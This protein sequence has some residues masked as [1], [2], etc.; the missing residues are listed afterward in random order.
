MSPQ[1]LNPNNP[2]RSDGHEDRLQSQGSSRPKGKALG[3]RLGVAG[4]TLMMIAPP[5]WAI[6]G[7]QPERSQRADRQKQ[8]QVR[9]HSSQPGRESRS[10]RRRESRRDRS[11]RRGSASQRNH[12]ESRRQGQVQ[13]RQERRQETRREH[14][15]DR[16]Q[17]RRSNQDRR[18]ER[19][20]NHDRRQEQRHEIRRERR[21]EHRRDHRADR[22][23]ERRQERRA[24]RN[25]QRRH[26][27][28]VERRHERR[29]DRRDHRYDR[30]DRRDHRYNRRGHDYRSDHYR[31]KKRHHR[32]GY[33][34]YNRDHYRVKR[35]YESKY[36]R[37]AR[38]REWIRR[39]NR[40]WY[41]CYDYGG[42]YVR[43]GRYLDYR[44]DVPRFIHY[45]HLDRY[46]EYY[47]GQVYHGPHDEIYDVYL[48]PVYLHDRVE[49]R[50]YVYCEGKFFGRARFDSYGGLKFEVGFR[51]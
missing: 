48:F 15:P 37:R 4:L 6:P 38:H 28:R 31:N 27:G 11:E 44:F 3:V 13:R 40:A 51:F 36:H 7:N 19:R 24:E 14:R 10:E 12:Q 20:R 5:V 34:Y 46:D 23:Q 49:Y 2:H 47:Y 1:H 17:E 41:D 26:E 33:R 39:Q 32:K 45:D 30:R 25:H 22:R 9:G 43:L 21:Q 18:Q 35:G 50:P 8:P 16:R 29:A 42:F